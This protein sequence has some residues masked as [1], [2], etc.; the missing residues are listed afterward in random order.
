[1]GVDEIEKD[2]RGVSRNVERREA[3]QIR[4][5]LERRSRRK[6]KLLHLLQRE[7]LL[8]D[9]SLECS[10]DRHA[11][12][13]KI[14]KEIG[15]P[16]K[17]RARA[18]DEKI[19]LREL[20]RILFLL[21]QRRG[22]KSNRKSEPKKNEK[23]GAV[24]GGIK[25][26]EE[27]VVEAGCR[28]IGEYFSTINSHKERIRT[29]YT[30][31]KM[32]EDEFEL[33][34]DKQRTFYPE[35]LTDSL[36]KTVRKTI[37]FQRPLKSQKGLIGECE[38]EPKRK[39]A[40]WALL[41]S[42]RFRY[43]QMLNNLE[44]I[45]PNG[46][47]R[48][49][50]PEERAKVI[51]KLEYEGDLTFAALKKLLG[52]KRN[53]P[54]TF[55]LERVDDKKLIGNRTASKLMPIFG[56]K[57]WQSFSEDERDAIVEDWRSITKDEVLK[58]R[59]MT[60]WGL[61]EES[62]E[63]FSHVSLQ[64]G[65]CNFS[66]V[67]IEKLL[68]ALEKGTP[69]QTA[70]RELYPDRWER[71]TEPLSFLPS[72]EKSGLTS[73]RNPIVERAL[74]ELR[75]LAN[76]IIKN[77]GKPG[78]IRVEM[79]RELRQ[80]SGQRGETHKAN[81]ARKKEREEAA[82]KICEEVGIENPS[83][84]D[85][86]RVLLA[87]ECDWKCPYTG[88]Q[89]RMS[90][91]LG[92]HPQFDIEHIIP[93]HR[94]LDDSYLNKTLCCADENRNVKKDQT[95][96]EAYHGTANWGDII[97]RVA[98][99]KG[100]AARKKLE[101]F[102]M[103]PEEFQEFAKG[104]TAR[105]L[106]DTRWASRWAKQYLGLLYG[107]IKEDGIDAAGKQ[108]VQT[109]SGPVT[110]FLRNTWGL[111]GI[112]GDG[113]FKTRDDHRHHAVDAVVT[114]LAEPSTVKM[115]S[116]ASKCGLYGSRRLFSDME[117]PWPGFRDEVEKT[118]K[119]IV[120][121]HRVSK[122]VRGA[123]HDRT[124]YG[125]PRY[126][127]DGNQRVYLRK[128]LKELNSSEIEL[129]IDKGIRDKVQEIVDGSDPTKVFDDDS[130]L[131]RFNLG[132][133]VKAVVKRVKVRHKFTK[134]FPLNSERYVMLKDKHHIA[135]FRSCKSGKWEAEVVSIYEAYC[136]LCDGQPRRADYSSK[137]EWKEAWRAFRSRKQ[138]VQRESYEKGEFLFSLSGG[139]IIEL[140]SENSASRDLFVVGTIEQDK[141]VSYVPINDARPKKKIGTK[142]FR[143]GPGKLQ[144]KN[145]RKVVI[146]PLGNIQY[147]ND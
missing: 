110:A 2:G 40:P 27:R 23:L 48:N 97:A 6:E 136:R 42:Q 51:D 25:S 15:C 147:A 72:I 119:A 56:R 79:A 43:L 144:N 84:D 75:H 145:C 80:T 138:I 108:R 71:A 129:I 10:A 82:G 34:W 60:R 3:R 24:K 52:Y 16:Y 96:Y 89:I 28:T 123:L 122:R 132:N 1:M 128:S 86:L 113:D 101:R 18:L 59:G 30:S 98:K 116:D 85:I 141:R 39:R 65:Y 77:Y 5:Q 57:R 66:K 54:T 35:L 107:G 127:E 68:P 26:L 58:K 137:E 49:L 13:N 22:F 121:S 112:L 131:P 115:L 143:S 114:A 64:D 44:L 120:T 37:F 95:P 118:V 93:F 14:D 12:L 106:N 117:A 139:D 142:G 46:E 63:I 53:E 17:L 124:L 62:A 36:K 134:P 81:K 99:F 41:I 135:Y 103:T 32:Y 146:G 109:T 7:G 90:D 55:N 100:N 9:G 126:D 21:G 29:R 105:Q 33:I 11:F 130:K 111:N 19:E 125:K 140:D 31:R 74:T 70:V 91:L 4:K 67:A 92:D 50:S 133:G 104:F 78:T 83:R 69:L 20:G 102:K 47:I 8:P 61:D 45:D 87:D 94:C 38:L 73:L 76:A 88:K